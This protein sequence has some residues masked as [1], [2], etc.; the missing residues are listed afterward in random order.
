MDVNPYPRPAVA[1]GWRKLALSVAGLVLVLGGAEVVIRLVDPPPR[2]LR[3]VNVAGYRLSSNP[4][5][6]YEYTPGRFPAGDGAFYDHRHF[7]I[8]SHG[9]R[10]DEWC[11][12]KEPHSMR[13]LVL[14]D[15]VT[16]GNGIENPRDTYPK[17]LERLLRE[18]LPGRTV[19]V[20]NMGVGGYHTLQEVETLREVGLSFNP[21]MVLVGFVINDF[22]E[23]MDGGVYQNLLN[24]LG[25]EERGVLSDA[26]TRTTWR[27]GQHL[28]GASRLLFFAYYRLKSLN[29]PRP[30][31][32][33]DYRRDVLKNQNAVERGLELLSQLQ[34]SRSFE[35]RVF[36][37][38][39]FDWKDGRYP[40]EALH[41]QVEKIAAPYPALVVTDLLPGLMR[42]AAEGGAL[43]FDGLHPN[44]RGHRLLAEAMAD[45]ILGRR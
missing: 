31:A 39:A 36:L 19:E 6:K 16:A 44:R 41:R 15:S 38:P 7:T 40:H 3:H 18:A 12:A 30:D 27:A 21:D 1:Q 22:D 8:N 42:K 2:V 5:R 24:Q 37:I 32:G 34:A 20:F 10:D 33:F 9:F 29:P 17:Q 11:L 26:F 28:L 25:G 23:D 45:E 43:A 13:I 14:G 35:A 4:V